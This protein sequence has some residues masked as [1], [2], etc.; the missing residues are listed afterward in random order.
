MLYFTWWISDRR[1]SVVF[2]GRE[3]FHSLAVLSQI[4]PT[5]GKLPLDFALLHFWIIFG[6]NSKKEVVICHKS[7]A[8]SSAILENNKCGNVPFECGRFG[9]SKP[10]SHY[11]AG[12]CQPLLWADCPQ[13]WAHPHPNHESALSHH[14]PWWLLG[15]SAGRSISS[16]LHPTRA[17]PWEGEEVFCCGCSTKGWLQEHG[18]WRRRLGGA[19][20]PAIV[21]EIFLLCFSHNCL[22]V[23]AAVSAA[24][25]ITGTVVGATACP[26]WWLPRGS[27]WS[28]SPQQC[29]PQK[30]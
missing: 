8:Q 19:G 7:V 27:A 28:L 4:V 14:S 22:A 20:F 18:S 1:V 25:R 23:A 16:C 5:F 24:H 13:D 9:Q 6:E 10:A 11:R 21:G 2:V 15:C 12:C 29:F 3:F 17:G 26:S 30:M